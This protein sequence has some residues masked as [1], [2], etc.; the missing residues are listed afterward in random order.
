M[1]DATGKSALLP[2][3]IWLL[4]ALFVLLN[5][6]QQV[7]PS[8][9]AQELAHAFQ[10]SNGSLGHMAAAYF[11]AYAVFQIPVGLIIDRFGAR[12][13]LALALL[14]AGLG[15]I[16]FAVSQSAGYALLA[17]VFMGASS[18]FSF[19]G[20]LKLVQDWFPI[21]RFSTLAGM[22]NTAAML[23]AASG[24]PLAV[25]V[26]A[27]GWRTSML[28]IGAVELLLAI[29][30]F[31][32]VR[33]RPGQ[34]LIP[35]KPQTRPRTSPNDVSN[36]LRNPQVWLNAAYATGISLIF[37]AFGGLWGSS[38][39]SKAYALD[40]V[41]AAGISALLFVGGMVGSLFFGWLSDQL[42]SRNQPMRL[43]AMGGLLTLCLLLYTPDLPLALFKAGLFLMGFFSSANIVAY[44]VARDLYPRITGFSIGFLS[45]CFYAG[46]AV[47]QPLVGLLLE[48]HARDHAGAGIDDLTVTDYRFALSALVVFMAVA[49]VSS[50]LLRE[51][52]QPD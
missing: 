48:Y 45:T 12:R 11:Y 20:C 17:R 28:G 44:A 32:V 51:T 36:V 42:H 27:L 10:V 22:T 31:L 34:G 39:I 30:M 33:D 14:M 29:L 1:T 50:L 18:A 47:S 21:S 40:T 9:V 2:W 8:L 37:V 43:A 49:L 24:A 41:A 38:F 46:S 23:G 15:A 26:A 4:A 6:V 19:L 13:P 5:Y 16:A 52:L 3:L 25:G 7:F 35:S